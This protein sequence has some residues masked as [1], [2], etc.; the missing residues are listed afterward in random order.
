MKVIN[1]VS[2]WMNYVAMILVLILM[3]LTVS[4][5]FMRFVFNSPI[6][7]TP[8]MAKFI[9][10]S[11]VLGVAWCAIQGEHISVDLVMRHFSPRVQKI[12]EIELILAELFLKLFRF[13]LSHGFLGFFH[14]CHHVT[15]SLYA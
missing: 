1:T 2:R 5:V 15:H 7:G 11:L 4:D 13:L 12:V 8:E 3:M 9:M 6:T 10:V 14:Q